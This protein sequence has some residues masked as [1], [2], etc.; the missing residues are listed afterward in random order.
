MAEEQKRLA[1]DQAVDVAKAMVGELADVRTDIGVYDAYYSGDQQPISYND[2]ISQAYAQLLTMSVS[3]WCRLIVDVVA[4]RLTVGSIQS[5]SEPVL[6]TTAWTYWQANN[7]DAGQ[8]QIHTEALKM[9]LCY[10]A[11]WPRDNMAPRIVG[12]S[13]TQVHVRY[14]EVTGLPVYGVKVW[15]GR[16]EGDRY[17]YVT[18]Y[19]QFAV[20]RFRSTAQGQKLESYVPRAPQTFDLSSLSLEPRPSDDDGGPELDNPMGRVPF[21]KFT[22]QPDLLGGYTSEI[23]GVLPIQDRINKTTADRMMT[24]EFHAFPQRW[25]TGIDIPVDPDTKQP[26]QPFD[27]AL[28]RLW[29]A[30]SP[31][32]S[33][34]QFPPNGSEGFLRAI[35][36]DIQAMSTQSRT[37][38]HYLI[39]GMGQFPSGESVRAT[40]YGLSRK[41]ESRQQTYGEAW[42]EVIRLAALAEGNTSLAEDVALHV[43]WAD[44]EARSEGELVDALLKMATLGVPTDALWER[45]GV[46]PQTI[47]RWKQQRAEEV[48]TQAGLGLA[49]GQGTATVP[50]TEP[51]PE[52]L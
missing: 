31:E 21:V 19:D 37:P 18:L 4:E 32:T 49:I 35:E 48:A 20:Y 46:P 24:Q 29:T 27:S 5:G 50:T 2:R 25:V 47:E 43:E 45:W 10:G 26:I 36:A 52:E 44:V 22:T 13:P 38:P 30:V 40:E 1:L 7:L 12:E 14:N 51:P 15:E 8:V 3:N 42:E 16:T 6:D 23:A 11:V 28:D 41:V 17:L 33:F 34:G 39:G 9:G